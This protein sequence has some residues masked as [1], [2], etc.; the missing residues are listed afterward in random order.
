MIITLRHV[1]RKRGTWGDIRLFWVRN[2]AVFSGLL[3]SGRS[4]CYGL[5]LGALLYVFL[6]SFSGAGMAVGHCPFFVGGQLL[7]CYGMAGFNMFWYW[8]LPA[9]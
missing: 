4:A 8:T 6:P 1:I 2:G 5:G 7:Q 9:R 3:I